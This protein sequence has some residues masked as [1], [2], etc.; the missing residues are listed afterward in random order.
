MKGTK[1]TRKPQF[2]D[3]P[4]IKKKRTEDSETTYESGECGQ[5]SRYLKD[6]KMINQLKKNGIT[7]LFPIQQATFSLIVKGHDLIAKDRTGSGKTLAYSLPCLE[8]MRSKGT[9]EKGNKPKILVMLPTRLVCFYLENWHCRL[10]V[11]L[12]SCDCKTKIGKF[13]PYMEDNL[14]ANKWIVS[15]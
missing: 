9:F 12:K 8:K 3:T 6:A 4:L 1:R 15:R 11:A 2:E 14:L 7:S 10:E 13:Q 5:L